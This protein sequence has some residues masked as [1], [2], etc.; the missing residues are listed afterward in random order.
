MGNSTSA[1]NRLRRTLGS[2]TAVQGPIQARGSKSELGSSIRTDSAA[3]WPANRPSRRKSR[4]MCPEVK[5]HVSPCGM[6]IILVVE[7]IYIDR[8][9][10]SWVPI[11]SKLSNLYSP[12]AA[13]Q[14][15]WRRVPEHKV[16]KTPLTRSIYICR[17]NK[18]HIM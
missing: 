17:Y 8:E 13:T 1:S 6:P 4:R 16:V 11:E 2:R 7:D 5:A 10:A 15:G 18:H 12:L 9:S 14:H 3:K